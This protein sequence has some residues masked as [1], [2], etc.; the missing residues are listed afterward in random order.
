MRWPIFR[1]SN[2]RQKETIVN[3]VR[4]ERLLLSGFRVM[5]ATARGIVLDIAQKALDKQHAEAPKPNR[6]GNVFSFDFISGK[7]DGFLFP[8]KAW[9][10]GH[11]QL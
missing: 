7:P 9:G 11:E 4:E 3:N 1:A 6:L 10:N 5:H 2:K 8:R